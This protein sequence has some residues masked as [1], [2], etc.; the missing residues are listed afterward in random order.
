VAHR[1]G[2]RHCATPRARQEPRQEFHEHFLRPAQVPPHAGRISSPKSSGSPKRFLFSLKNSTFVVDSCQCYRVAF[3]VSQ[4]GP[5]LQ[6]RVLKRLRSRYDGTLPEPRFMM[7]GDWI[8]MPEVPLIAAGN[9]E[10]AAGEEGNG[11][12][13]PGDSA[14]AAKEAIG[15]MSDEVRVDRATAPSDDVER[16]DAAVGTVAPVLASP[17]ATAVP[18]GDAAPA[19]D[20]VAPPLSTTKRTLE[21]TP[22]RW[23]MPQSSRPRC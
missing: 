8:A 7:E 23:R 11:T 22:R 1:C 10:A 2:T 5:R 18:E 19:P 9:S 20:E 16:A 13:I 14:R 4:I 21:A 17:G 6:A 15:P 12:S 3:D